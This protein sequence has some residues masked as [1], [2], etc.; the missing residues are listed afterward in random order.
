MVIIKEE[1]KKIEIDSE[2]AE[3]FEYLN[4]IFN[5]ITEFLQARDGYIDTEK[6]EM[7]FE[8]VSSPFVFW[9]E[10]RTPAQAPIPTVKEEEKTQYMKA[11]ESKYGLIK[12][13]GKYSLKAPLDT[14]KFREL[15]AKMKEAGYKWSTEKKGFIEVK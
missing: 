13:D 7:F 12:K 14:L 8:R 6:R 15:A 3:Y 11:L 1:L 10:K 5:E 9:K 2:R 4:K